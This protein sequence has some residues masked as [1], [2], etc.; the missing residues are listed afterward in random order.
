[1]TAPIIVAVDPVEDAEARD[2]I[3]LAA[4][5][6]Q[7][8]RAELRA[9]TVCDPA[10]DPVAAERA[11]ADLL[12]ATGVTAGVTA[13]RGDSPA[14]RLHELCDREHPSALVIGSG[15]PTAFGDA[16][17]GAVAEPLLHGGSAPV[18]IAVH[19]YAGFTRPFA[20]IGIGFAGTPESR[21]ALRRATELADAT[22]ARL[23]VLCVAETRDWPF[24]TGN[25]PATWLEGD[26]ATALAA[27]SARLDLL[28]VGSRSYGPL[29]AVLL[30]AA[31]RQL[32]PAAS[33]PV[34]IVPRV[35]DP[36]LEPALVGG[37]E[38]RVVG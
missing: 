4:R 27:E 2:A 23:K 3:T 29:G 35:A 26:P 25:L 12:T 7:A 8:H 6:A 33:C 30:G 13:I 10:A 9:V 1:M 17:L 5:L 18:A 19:G 21:D 32:V 37:M 36:A 16:R 20:T 14:R 38:A 34:L 24:D 11:V 31:T 22:G 15:R 28:V